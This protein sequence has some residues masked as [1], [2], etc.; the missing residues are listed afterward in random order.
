MNKELS[1]RKMDKEAIK[2]AIKTRYLNSY[3][4]I[5]AGWRDFDNYEF[6]KEKLD[7]TFES[8]GD[9]DTHPIEIISGMASHMEPST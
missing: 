4:V 2:H 6:L 1:N 5:V 8:L 7:E 3:K 9:L